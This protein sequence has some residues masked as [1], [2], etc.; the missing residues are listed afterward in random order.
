MKRVVRTVY[1]SIRCS[2]AENC[3]LRCVVCSFFFLLFFW[4]MAPCILSVMTKMMRLSD[5]KKCY[6]LALDRFFVLFACLLVIIIT[7]FPM[8]KIEPISCLS[9]SLFYSLSVHFTFPFIACVFIIFEFV[10]IAVLF[11][12]F[13]YGLFRSFYQCACVLYNVALCFFFRLRS[14]HASWFLFCSIS[15]IA[16][17]CIC[18]RCVYKAHTHTTRRW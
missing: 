12:C 14:Q 1:K 6:Q 11:C 18:C 10:Q 7:I 3:R 4:S 13:L 5:S 9:L 17:N 15:P 16:S 8:W 2:T